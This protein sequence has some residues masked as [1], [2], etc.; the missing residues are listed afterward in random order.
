MTEQGFTISGEESIKRY[1]MGVHI[2]R[3][4]MEVGMGMTSR[5]ST[6]RSAQH[7]YGIQATTKKAALEELLDLYKRTYGTEYGS[8]SK[9]SKS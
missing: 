2:A 1:Q 5:I 7:K 3:L 8:A 9:G 6:L 4:K